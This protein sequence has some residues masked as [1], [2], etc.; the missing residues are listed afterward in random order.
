MRIGV[1]ASCWTNKRGY[2]RYTRGLLRALLA[3]DRRNEYC[4]FIDAATAGAAEELPAQAHPVVVRTTRAA[5]RSASASGH[6]SLRD[7]WAMRQAVGRHRPP[8]DLIFFPAVYTFFPVAGRLKV[9][10]AIHDTIA[11]RHPALI[12]PHWRARLLWTAKVRWAIRQAHLVTTVSQS[13]R[14]ALIEQFGIR[15]EI[16][17]VIPD[18]ADPAFRPLGRDPG[19]PS[20]LAK[21]GLYGTERFILYVG[22]LSPHKNL[23]TLIDAYARLL[24]RNEYGDVRLVLVGD[25]QGDVFFSS[26]PGLREM[27][28]ESGLASRVSFT[29]YVPD[30][31]LVHLYNAAQVLVLPSFDEGFGLPVLEAMACGTPVVASRI[32]ALLGLAGGAGIYFEP[33]AADELAHR[34]DEVLSDAL[35]RQALGREGL[36]RAQL[37][38]WERSAQAALAAFDEVISPR[39]S[40]P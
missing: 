27:A 30:A 4:W 1:D 34:L 26:Y 17:R 22:G 39:L 11:E 36:S 20:V 9:V 32:P 10:V 38:S 29:G 6:R 21:Y 31:E 18:A 40:A 3:A 19:T 14:Q 16:I 15:A 5:E 7:V 28:H 33:R 2:G 8:L 23:T 13:A 24:R 37:F 25:F 12:F 35:L